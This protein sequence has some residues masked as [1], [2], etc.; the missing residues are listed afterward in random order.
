MP[1]QGKFIVDN[2]HLSPLIVPGVGSFMAFSG[3]EIYRNRGGCTARPN[4]GP[5]PAGKYWIVDRPAGSIRS[6]MHMALRDTV[7][8]ALYSPVD[9]GEW[10]ALYRDDG[11]IDDYTWVEGVKRGNFRLHPAGGSG[12]SLGCITLQN[13]SDYAALRR[14]ILN[15]TPVH[16][17]NSG[18][19]TYG[20]IDVT[21]YGSTCP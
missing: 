16:A 21:T 20:W 15:T 10:F 5:I 18:L 6:R 12:I 2:Q 11:Q 17:R 3:N 19:S 1:L 13:R 4:I 14:A 9:H 7:M 8:S